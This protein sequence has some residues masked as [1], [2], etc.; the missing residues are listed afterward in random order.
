[1]KIINLILL[2]FIISCGLPIN[3]NQDYCK[4]TT[5]K[6]IA[7]YGYDKTVIYCCD[8]LEIINKYSAYIWLG[9]EKIKIKAQRVY[10]VYL[11]PYES[12]E[13]K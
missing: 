9:G 6:L 7:K 3:K 12:K 4:K 8:S 13:I 11:I 1:M 2:T 10:P 5:V